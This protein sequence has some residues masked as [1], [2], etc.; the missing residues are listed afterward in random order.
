M[1][2]KLVKVGLVR[3]FLKSRFSDF[4]QHRFFRPYHAFLNLAS[5]LLL[6]TNS[7]EIIRKNKACLQMVPK[8]QKIISNFLKFAG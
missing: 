6:T 1:D 7:K 4:P 8:Q 2:K 3:L 5:K